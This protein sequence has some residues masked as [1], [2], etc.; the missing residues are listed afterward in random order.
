M[1]RF[2]RM[3]FWLMSLYSKRYYAAAQKFASFE[4]IFFVECISYLIRFHDSFTKR[5]T[6]EDLVIMS[7]FFLFQ[8]SVLI[9]SSQKCN[10]NSS[11]LL[12][13]TNFCLKKIFELFFIIV[14]IRPVG[15]RFYWIFTKCHA[16]HCTHHTIVIRKHYKKTLRKHSFL[17]SFDMTNSTDFFNIFQGFLPSS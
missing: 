9:L 16:K 10:K 11:K 6:H 7:I 13:L 4:G 3:S 17:F 14:V 2:L 5:L 15:Y 12:D 1:F 8:W